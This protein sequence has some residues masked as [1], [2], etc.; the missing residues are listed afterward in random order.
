[1]KKTLRLTSILL[2]FMMLL[3]L[4]AC[5]PADAAK[6]KAKMEKEKYEVIVASETK[7]GEGTEYEMDMLEQYREMFSKN[8]VDV[9]IASKG[10]V[11][12]QDGV[13]AWYFETPSQAKEAFEKIE[14]YIKG[15]AEQAKTSDYECKRS[16][17]VV[18]AGTKQGI[19]DFK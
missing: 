6:A 16:G 13:T 4:T 3:T 8:L 19:K 7:L 1:M 2:V 17:K 11:E 18:Y 9:V 10:E 15:A 14:T 5:V 12:N